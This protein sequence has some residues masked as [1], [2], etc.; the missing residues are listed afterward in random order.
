M[1]AICAVARQ[2]RYNCCCTMAKKKTTRTRTTAPNPRVAEPAGSPAVLRDTA[3]ETRTLSDGNAPGP[4]FE[5]I[6]EAAYH[7]Y[8]QRGGQD[9]HDFDDW[10]DAERSLRSR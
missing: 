3:N 9:G 10:L 4:T 5:Q 8:L 7:R 2:G 6:S 1:T